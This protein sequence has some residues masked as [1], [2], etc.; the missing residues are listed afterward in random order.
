M[1]SGRYDLDQLTHCVSSYT[2][3][4][5]AVHQRANVSAAIKPHGPVLEAGMTFGVQSSVPTK[6]NYSVAGRSALGQLDIAPEEVD[7]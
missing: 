5:K 2:A 6:C 3:A 1:T 4:R 7:L